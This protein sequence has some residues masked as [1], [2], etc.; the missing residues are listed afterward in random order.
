[1]SEREGA[2]GREGDRKKEEEIQSLS[3]KERREEGERARKRQID[4]STGVEEG[5]ELCRKDKEN[6]SK[7]LCQR[8]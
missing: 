5:E 6:C 4:Y 8:D 1:M 3:G 7:R 2:I